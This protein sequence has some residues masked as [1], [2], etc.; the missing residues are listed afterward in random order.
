MLL[1]CYPRCSTCRRAEQWLKHHQIEYDYRDIRTN[2]PD[3][4]ELSG[5]YQ[6]SGQPLKRFWNTSGMHYR[7]LNLKER[8]IGMNEE[9]QLALMASDGM[10]IRRP[11][12]VGD[13]FVL[14][15]FREKEWLDHLR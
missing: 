13:D 1:V 10:L 7:T 8:L 11:V 9:E 12:L 6:T 15:G 2:P 5:W 14:V 3:V 4:A